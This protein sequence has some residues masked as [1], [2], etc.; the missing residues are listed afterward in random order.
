MEGLESRQ[1]LSATLTSSGTLNVQGTGHADSITVGLNPQNTSMLDVSMNGKTRSFDAADVQ[2]INV[3]AG[4]GKDNVSLGSTLTTPATILGGAGNDTLT[5]GSGDDTLNGGTGND[6]LIGGSG[7][8]NLVG[9]TGNDTIECGP[10]QSQVNGGTGKDSVQFTPT[11][12]VALDTLPQAVQTGLTTLAQGATISD[13]QVFQ[14]D[15]QT[16]YGTSVTI[17]SQQTRIVVD[18]SGNPVGNAPP[19]SGGGSPGGGSG[20]QGQGSQGNGPAAPAGVLGPVISTDATAD[21]ITLTAS[22]PW[23]PPKQTTFKVTSTTA[24]TADGNTVALS[25]LTAGTLVAVQ[26]SGADSTTAT[27]I[28]ALDRRVGGVVTAID[29]TADTITIK[30]PSGTSTTYTVSPTAT[31]TLDGTASTFSAI[32]TTLHVQLKLAA[33]D[34]TVTSIISDP[35]DSSG[36]G[37]GDSGNPGG[38][39]GDPTSGAGNPGGT[40]GNPGGNPT[41]LGPHGTVVS[42]DTAADTITLQVGTASPTSYTLTSTATVTLDGAA[43][44]L[45][46]LVAGDNAGL[47]LS[48]DGTTVAAIQ[49]NSPGTSANPGGNTGDPTGGSGN[50]G[51]SSGNPGG[52]PTQLGPYGTVVSV[53]TTADTITL[54][55]GAGSSTT[56]SLAST[57]TVTL[58]GAASTLS[59]L[60]AG[61]NAGLQLS[62]DGK[63]VTAIQANSPSASGDPGTPTG[64][65]PAGSG[66]TG[67]P[68]G[69]P[70]AGSGNSG[71]PTGGSGNPGGNPAPLGPHGAIVSADATTDTITLQAGTASPTTYTVASTATVTLDGAAS[72]LS[73]LVAGDNAGLKLS[74][75][76][77]TVIAIQANSPATSGMPS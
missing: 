70:P 74:S 18:S 20:G 24:I 13:V 44:T 32:T 12:G 45:S 50:P 53:D 5:A 56:Y 63:T 1:L 68:T 26:T 61:D 2:N 72:S 11:A 22:N 65:P 51:G 47:Q 73:S 19:G 4:G 71:G 62:S 42:V 69:N 76:G 54:Q 28:T 33:L 58:D 48:S 10:G 67:A 7:Q 25:A 46:A 52:N 37:P 64:S 36:G 77:V 27:S 16:Y 35:Q 23:G 38:S 40:S 9:G 34:G 43:S 21:T 17:D 41:Q 15:H 30:D 8:D 57:A 31:V 29:T 6:T 66:N 59:A 49:A 60:G 39:A 75:D 14:D 55:S 3:N